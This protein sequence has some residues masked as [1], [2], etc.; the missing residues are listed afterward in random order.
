MKK[1]PEDSRGY[2]NDPGRR[3]WRDFSAIFRPWRLGGIV[4]DIDDVPSRIPPRRAFL[5]AAAQRNKWLVFDC[6]CGTG[7]RLTVN[8]DEARYPFWRLR[9]ARGR[10][11]TLSPSVDYHDDL[12]SCHY[13]LWKGRVAWTGSWLT[14]HERRRERHHA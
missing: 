1:R 14:T 8:L 12:R 10:R 9:I 4:S 6:P 3:S 7:H 2:N 13:F 11:I 5:V